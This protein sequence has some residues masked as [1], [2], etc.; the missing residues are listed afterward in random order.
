MEQHKDKASIEEPSLRG[1]RTH[2][3]SFN[4]LRNGLGDSGQP[5]GLKSRSDNLLNP[6][7]EFEKSDKNSFPHTRLSVAVDRRRLQKKKHDLL[8]QF[9]VKTECEKEK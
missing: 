8:K 5:F 2:S 3:P 6:I 7:S 9:E 4:F 1:L